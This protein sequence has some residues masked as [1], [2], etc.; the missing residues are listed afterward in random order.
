MASKYYDQMIVCDF[1]PSRAIIFTRKDAQT[2][3]WSVR[4]KRNLVRSSPNPGKPVRRSKSRYY[5][6]SLRT[7]DKVEA[8]ARARNVFYDF[9]AQEKRGIAPTSRN[10]KSLFQLWMSDVR[11]QVSV[12][13]FKAICVRSEDFIHFFGKVN[14]NSVDS[15]AF[16]A[17]IEWRCS[18]D[19]YQWKLDSMLHK[20]G[21]GGLYRGGAVKQKPS[22]ETLVQYRQILLQFLRW[23][24]KESYITV[25]PILESRFKNF[26]SDEDFTTTRVS[27]KALND[28]VWRR[29]AQLLSHFAHPR[30]DKMYHSDPRVKFARARLYAFLWFC[31]GSLARTQE[32]RFVKWH[33]VTRHDD[34][35]G[36]YFVV[37]ITHPKS[38]A[39]SF[40]NNERWTILSR[41]TS[42]YLTEWMELIQGLD[43]YYDDGY[44]FPNWVLLK[45]RYDASS[46]SP[47]EIHLMS[48]LFSRLL[49]SKGTT[50]DTTGRK[51]TMN[52]W[53]RHTAIKHALTTN[54]NSVADVALRAGN[55]LQTIS[56]NYMEYYV[57]D[58][59]KKLASQQPKGKP[60]GYG[61]WPKNE[62][63]VSKYFEDDSTKIEREIQSDKIQKVIEEEPELDWLDKLG[64]A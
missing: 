47:V 33:D 36:F 41:Q 63:R 64:W 48:R 35:D 22:R 51:I 25:I 42:Q 49:A 7:T 13:R 29:V 2:P 37:R 4:I 43:L 60:V 17:F 38:T 23:S 46:L 9:R 57:E 44:I 18:E 5:T 26:L 32:A 39:R 1:E 20:L 58:N 45:D 3:T 40:P 56:S 31:Y 16:R 28:K 24:Y 15:H 27:S 14:I 59:A 10:F 21:P 12:A 11:G 34:E 8:M 30:G 61:V 19:R 6:K 52:S 54:D 53:C 55:T 50:H 62:K